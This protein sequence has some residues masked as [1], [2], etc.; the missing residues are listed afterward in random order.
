MSLDV[1]TSD[2]VS[3]SHSKKLFYVKQVKGQSYSK[4]LRHSTQVLNERN[5][6]E[7]IPRGIQ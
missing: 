2:S 4:L 6:R 5:Y 1:N 7:I 3:H